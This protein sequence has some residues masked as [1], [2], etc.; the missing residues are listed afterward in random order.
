MGGR[1]KDRPALKIATLAGV[2]EH[3][4]SAPFELW[5]RPCG[6]VVV[7]SFNECA[8]N[9]TNVDLVDLLEWFRSG[10]TGER[11]LIHV[12]EYIATLPTS[13]RN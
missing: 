13:K 8:N 11:S 2:R 1:R 4:D 7:R 10:P 5:V 6:R 12:G 9:Y 3:T